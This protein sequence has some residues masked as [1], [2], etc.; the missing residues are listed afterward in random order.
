MADIL[1]ATAAERAPGPAT[2]GRVVHASLA[3]AAAQMIHDLFEQAESR[4]PA[5]RCRW[6]ALV[7]SNNYRIDRIRH[8]AAARGLDITIV[9]DIV[10]VI[11]YC[12]RAAEDLHRTHPARAAWVGETV[13]T[14]LEGHSAHF[15]PTRTPNSPGPSQH[16]RWSPDHP[17]SRSAG[18]TG[19]EHPVAGPMTLDQID[20]ATTVAV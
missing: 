3:H 19:G 4:D 10:H 16:R 18:R 6:V 12:W 15:R 17:T 11:E 8:E 7:D 5:H 2:G 1:P 9:I 13:R 20:G 14:I